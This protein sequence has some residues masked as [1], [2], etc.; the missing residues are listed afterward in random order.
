MKPKQKHKRGKAQYTLDIYTPL[1][2]EQCLERLRAKQKSYSEG[3]L[4]VR[5]KGPKF[6]IEFY[7]FNRLFVPY[8]FMGQFEP[9]VAGT[10]VYGSIHRQFDHLE[11]PFALILVV[12]YITLVSILLVLIVLI[13]L[14]VGMVLLGLIVTVIMAILLIGGAAYYLYQCYSHR[15]SES[16]LRWIDEQLNVEAAD[17]T[18]TEA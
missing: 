2:R 4:F 18:K 1:T 9:Y 12:I 3:R 7:K 15:H 8:R 11:I 5:N 6:T 10:H 14:E 17:A 13:G 16:L